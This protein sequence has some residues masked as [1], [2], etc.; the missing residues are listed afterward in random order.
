[1][2]FFNYC[3][4]KLFIFLYPQLDVANALT[5]RSVF[6]PKRSRHLKQMLSRRTCSDCSFR[7][8]RRLTSNY[9][10][11][12]PVWECLWWLK[13][14]S[15]SE[16]VITLVVESLSS[17]RSWGHERRPEVNDA[18]VKVLR[19]CLSPRGQV[20]DARTPLLKFKIEREIL[21][22]ESS[23]LGTNYS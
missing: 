19:M 22:F 17:R 6:R 1:M 20:A 3:T 13:S 16:R 11:S 9:R 21:V 4:C 15:W 8:S 12:V 23:R 14:P 2:A 7:V 10:T 5:K 18:S